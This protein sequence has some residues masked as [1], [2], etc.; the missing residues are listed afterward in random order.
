MKRLRIVLHLVLNIAVIV[1]IVNTIIIAKNG[2]EFMTE[3]QAD[4]Q[5]AAHFYEEV[6][7]VLQRVGF[8]AEFY[9]RYGN[10]KKEVKGTGLTVGELKKMYQEDKNIIYEYEGEPDSKAE[11]MYSFFND[12]RYALEIKS[13]LSFG[14]V[15]NL[16]FA[17][18]YT[19]QDGSPVRY[20]NVEYDTILKDSARYCSYFLFDQA[21]NTAIMETL[22]KEQ[23]G[24]DSLV[25]KCKTF[26]DYTDLKVIFAVDTEYPYN[27]SYSY[28]DKDIVTDVSKLAKRKITISTIL[29]S[30]IIAIVSMVALI[31][32]TG[33]SKDKKIKLYSF[34][35]LWWDIIGCSMAAVAA[36]VL[37][38]LESSEIL[39]FYSNN[40]YV[41]FGIFL[42]MAIEGS[43]IF[44][45]SIVRRMKAKCFWKTSAV[46]VL[47]YRM[48]KE[49]KTLWSNGKASK[50]AASM[51]VMVLIYLVILSVI[52]GRAYFYRD[53][54]YVFQW[55]LL[56]AGGVI[57]VFRLM[58]QFTAEY[59]A[60]ADETKNIAEGDITNKISIPIKFKANKKMAEAVNNIG[61]GINT[62]V[63]E[64]VKNERMKSDLITNVSHD[65]KTPLTS[66]INYV[67]LLRM[68]DIQDEKVAN[69][70]RVLD[71]KSQRLKILTDDLVEASKLSSGVIELQFDKL[72]LVELIRQ[73]AGEYEEKFNEKYLEVVMNLPMA[74]VYVHADGRK[75][76]RVLENLYG[77]IYKYA[78]K[79]TRVY[80][81]LNTVHGKVILT[82]KNISNSPLNFESDELTERFI[83]GDVSRSTEGSGL[84]LSIAK[85][86]IDRHGGTF[87]ILLDGDLF[88]VVIKLKE[89]SELNEVEEQNPNE[90]Q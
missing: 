39:K 80:V 46:G 9:D 29:I 23:G 81:D 37:L 68:E 14:T 74:P 61:E 51:V 90:N 24:F 2:F 13:Y 82:V 86:I 60:I 45:L 50:K 4:G 75:M 76:W 52:G 10:D 35:S 31:V 88:K 26:T 8:M 43:V 42:F 17:V 85:S 38:V 64:S 22:D 33:K 87:K 77:N 15:T 69:Y 25:Y 11:A 41:I 34:D 67:N 54:Y 49:L 32:L 19:A 89:F 66:I 83:R 73:S 65:I 6:S 63:A 47:L 16:V 59:N 20:G 1:C 12:Y 28:Y 7:D 48:A 78:L 58:W 21:N 71:E 57:L 70:I 79:G 56:V 36:V 84:G 44:F 72:N 5:Y 53:D 27:D 62:A 30:G 3:E 40:D 55:M 18:Q